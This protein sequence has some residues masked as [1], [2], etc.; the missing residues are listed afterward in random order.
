[1]SATWSRPLRV[2]II[3]DTH[4]SQ[5]LPSREYNNPDRSDINPTVIHGWCRC[6]RVV[7]RTKLGVQR[8]DV[9]SYRC[10]LCDARVT[11]G[12]VRLI[13]SWLYCNSYAT[14]HCKR[15]HSKLTIWSIGCIY[16]LAVTANRRR[17]ERL[18]RMGLR[19][20]LV[21]DRVNVSLTRPF[22]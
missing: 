21:T 11:Y 13:R 5:H 15:S 12:H 3:Q 1:M 6:I 17:C 7:Y 22:A 8:K 9:V 16:N 2:R 18:I 10:T 14:L 19:C 20:S 4:C